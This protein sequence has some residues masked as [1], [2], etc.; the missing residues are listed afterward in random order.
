M[1]SL[2]CF[3]ASCVSVSSAIVKYPT[4]VVDK[5]SAGPDPIGDGQENGAR[6]VLHHILRCK[7]L[8]GFLVALLVEAPN[9]VPEDRT[10]AVIFRTCITAGEP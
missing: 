10:H 1:P 5:V 7:V 9:Q 6:H 8:P 4:V 3:K 2:P